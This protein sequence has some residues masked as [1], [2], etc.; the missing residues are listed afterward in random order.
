M[1]VYMLKSAKANMQFRHSAADAASKVPRSP[2][3]IRPSS[4]NLG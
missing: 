1:D 4:Y 2:L 3:S